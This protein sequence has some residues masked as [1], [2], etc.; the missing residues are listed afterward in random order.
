MYI[1]EYENLAFDEHGNVIQAGHEPSLTVQQVTY[2]AT[3]GASTAFQ[4]NT[5]FIRVSCDAAAYLKFGL[6]PTAVTL[7]DL[8]VQAN[9][10]EFFG[11]NSGQQIAAVA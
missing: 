5:R 11:V 1:S 7:V 6:A 4:A 10:P 3:S 8:P 2:T 9:T